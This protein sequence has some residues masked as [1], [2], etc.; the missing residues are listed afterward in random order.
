VEAAERLSAASRR[1]LER[2]AA[3]PDLDAFLGHVLVAAAETFGAVAGGVW[4]AEASERPHLLL[5]LEDGEVR[6]PRGSDPAMAFA[7]LPADTPFVPRR[8]GEITVRDVAESPDYLAAEALRAYLLAR[9][10]ATVMVI[11]MVLGEALRGAL[12]LRFLER[13]RLTAGE[14]DLAHALANQAVLAMEL[15]RLTRAARAAAV[16]EERNRLARD[17]HDTLAQGLA[18]IVRQL[19]SA[20]ASGSKEAAARHISVATE[21]ARESLVE[22]R[23]S[24][25][26]LRP[27]SLDGRTLEGAIRDL[28]EKSARVSPA[29]IRLVTS[30]ERGGVPSHVED[31]LLRIV[32]EALTNAIKH[33]GAAAI[34]VDLAFEGGSVRLAVRDDGAGFDV[35]GAGG[36]GV[37]LGSMDER[38]RRIGAAVTVA[39]EPGAGTE[40]LVYWSPASSKDGER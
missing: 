40:V 7:E 26:A 39:S 37:G 2:F 12:S 33:A 10:I 6:T 15:T 13:R 16:N 14:A 18:A 21:I 4:R 36:A 19:E 38:A 3:N 25:R 22:A 1:T 28:L 9:G 31:E 17:I 35:A 29:A 30:G 32:S 23:R 20:G 8:R 27:S 11:P 5:M 24:I 34:D